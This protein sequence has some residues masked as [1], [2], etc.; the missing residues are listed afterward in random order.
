MRDWRKKNS[1]LESFMPSAL[2]KPVEPSSPRLFRLSAEQR[3]IPRVKVSIGGRFM[4]ED[5]TEHGGTA[6]EAS[7]QAIAIETDVP[8]RLNERVVGY[9]YTVGRVEGKVIRLTDTGFIL[10]INTTAMKRDRLANQLTWL[11]NRDILNLP[12]D[13]RH[14]RVVPRDPRILVRNKA[15]LGSEPV[16]GHLIDV[17]RSG[18]AVSIRGTFKLGDEI[19]LGTTPARVVRA[20]D[21]GVAVEFH[22][23]VPDAMFD[24][25]IRL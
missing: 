11:A 22:G 5:R 14:D 17:S 10:D 1:A 12:E 23:S 15:D 7:V 18:A 21:G 9:F 13:R 16:W 24:V 25:D 4:L 19:M 6:V 20:F 3:R 2:L 8:V